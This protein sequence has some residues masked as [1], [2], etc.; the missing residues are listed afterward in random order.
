MRAWLQT[1]RNRANSSLAATS[2]LLLA[3]LERTEHVG[4]VPPKFLLLWKHQR[5]W[6]EGTHIPR[7]NIHRRFCKGKWL[8][9]LHFLQHSFEAPSTHAVHFP[10]PFWTGYKT[11]LNGRDFQ[12]LA[13]PLAL[14]P[15]DHQQNSCKK[16]PG[17]MTRPELA[18]GLRYLEEPSKISKADLQLM[19]DT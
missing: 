6:P 14:E 13:L 8:Q 12:W 7:H 1:C 11:D 5:L 19:A 18:L 10:S 16:Q 15:C 4:S 3:W 9:M 17:H 2:L